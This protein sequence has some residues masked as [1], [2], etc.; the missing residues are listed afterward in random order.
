MELLAEV[1][2]PA[3]I[4]APVEDIDL[5]TWL[6]TLRNDEYRSCSRAHIAGATSLAPDG[7]RMSINVEMPGPDLLVENYIESISER[8]RCLVHSISDVLTASGKWTTIDVVWEISVKRGGSAT[9]FTNHVRV[10]S[11]DAYIRYLHEAGLDDLEVVKRET[12]RILDAHS[13]EETPLFAKNIE[14][15]AIE[16]I[17]SGNR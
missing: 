5:T 2:T 8:G 17:W 15:K 11:T 3:M 4:A 6:F 14:K 16:R 13:R 9:E 7:K 10:G 1:F 12:T